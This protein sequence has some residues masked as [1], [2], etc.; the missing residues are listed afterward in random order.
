MRFQFEQDKAIQ[1]MAYIVKRLGAVQKVKLMKLI[2][3]ADKTHFLRVGHP[4]TGDRPCAMP[5]G[6]VPSATLDLLNGNWPEPDLAMQTLHLTDNTVM[7]RHDPGTG[8]LSPE[9]LATLDEILAVHG[10]T[11][12]W[13]LVDATHDLPEYKE[14]RENAATRG[15]R[16]VYITYESI[17]KYAGDESHYRL[18]R[19]VV[20]SETV[21]HLLCPLNAGADA[22]L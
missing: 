3:L 11:H 5:H 13:T 9:E 15:K 7:L 6:P 21:G 19:P 22:D 16:S 18:N 17:L 14:A 12:H 2:Y 8:A 10:D 20:S 1:T 4:I